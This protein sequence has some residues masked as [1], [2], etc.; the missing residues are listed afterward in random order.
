LAEIYVNYSPY[1]YVFNNP[2]RYTD[3]TGMGPDDPPGTKGDGGDNKTVIDPGHGGKDPG[4]EKR[5][6]KSHEKD[7]NLTV[8]HDIMMRKQVCG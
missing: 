7:I 8:T 6:G 4:A 1:N 3:P 2:L 5:N